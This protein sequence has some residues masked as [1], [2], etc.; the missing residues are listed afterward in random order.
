MQ[1]QPLNIQIRDVRQQLFGPS[2]TGRRYFPFSKI[3]EMLQEP[4]VVD[5]QPEWISLLDLDITRV[6]PGNEL[7]GYTYTCNDKWELAMIEYKSQNLNL[8]KLS[9]EKAQREEQMFNELLEEEMLAD[10]KFA[11]KVPSIMVPAAPPILSNITSGLALPQPAH[12]MQQALVEDLEN[13]EVERML[14]SAA[15]DYLPLL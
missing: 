1:Q 15:D 10:L 14:K 4:V 8:W 11:P 7:E 12:L 5:I 2:L 13:M 9:E 6:N 3:T